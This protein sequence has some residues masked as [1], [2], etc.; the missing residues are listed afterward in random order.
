[1]HESIFLER[2]ENL[3]LDVSVL[4]NYKNAMIE[5]NDISLIS[6]EDG[7]LTV[8]MEEYGQAMH[9]LS[10]AYQESLHKHVYPSRIL[11]KEKKTIRILD[12]GFGLGYNIVAAFVELNKNS[13]EKNLEVISFEKE[14]RHEHFLNNIFF[15]DQRDIIFEK[16]KIAFNKGEYESDNVRI[17]IIFDDGRTSIQ[18]IDNNVFDAIFHDPFS[19]SKNPELWTIDFFKEEYRVMAPGGILTT[20]SSAPQVRMGLMLAGF[21][22][23]RG[24][25]FGAKREGTLASN[26]KMD[27]PL[28][29]E[30]VNELAASHKSIPYRDE[31]FLS[32]RDKI[33]SDRLEEMRQKRITKNR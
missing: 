25:A 30:Y 22:V 4:N 7:T 28:S 29:S 31:Y 6:T 2:I 26:E 11:H 8:R 14:K 33:L 9:T 32:S 17:K 1:M 13:P 20:Y 10:G 27:D 16:L 19:P 12:V 23:G 5:P 3:L 18:A 21:H 15:N 24:P